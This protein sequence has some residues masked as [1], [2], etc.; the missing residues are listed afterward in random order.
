[1]TSLTTI[2]HLLSLVYFEP[3]PADAALKSANSSTKPTEA[4][5]NQ[6]NRKQHSFEICLLTDMLTGM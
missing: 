1:M 2:A 6:C 5:N 3:F 4:N